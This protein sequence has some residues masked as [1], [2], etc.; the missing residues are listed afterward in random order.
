MDK[1]QVA[2]ALE[3]IA[4]LLELKDENPFKVRA[5]LAA[6]RAIE[7]LTADLGTL[8]DEHK[9]LEIPGIG[10]ALEEKITQLVKTGKMDYLEEL[11]R[12]VPAGLL[13]MLS[14][15]SFGPKKARAVWKKLGITSL[16]ELRT[17]CQENRIA[18]LKGFGEKTQKKILE[19]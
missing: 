8:V 2:G 15:P 6:A 3:S 19:G 14:I 7:G 11:R 18:G 4:H 12:E 16:A 13:E 1:S 17:A 5:Y 10:K 9:L